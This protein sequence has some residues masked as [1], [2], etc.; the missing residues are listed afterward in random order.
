MKILFW[1]I[2]TAPT[3]AFVWKIWQENVGVNQIIEPGRVLSWAAKWAHEDEVYHSAEWYAGD[4]PMIEALHKMLSEADAVV[5]FNGNHFDIPVMNA[6]FAKYGLH[7]PAPFK[8]IDL[9]QVVK[10]KFRLLS[11]RLDYVCKY[12][13]LGEKAKTGG[14]QL[15]VDV[16][17]GDK[18]AR[19]KF[20]EYNIHDV[21]LTEVLYAHILPW[22]SNHPQAGHF[23]DSDFVCPTC[24]GTHLQKRG[25]YRTKTFSYQRY[26]CNDCGS[27]SRNRVADKTQPTNQLVG[28]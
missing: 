24:G 21:E 23:T 28:I 10:K 17:N 18:Q 5:T 6:A 1:D 15:W 19:E 11:N 20:I 2:E 25:L 3:Q 12:F 27:W 9:Y 4:R 16:L 7:P 13:G 14:F 8:S 22:I 26:Q